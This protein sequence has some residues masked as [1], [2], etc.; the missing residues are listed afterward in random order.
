MKMLKYLPLGLVLAASLVGVSSASAA[1]W[2]PTTPVTGTQVGSSTLTAGTSQVT[3]PTG[4]TTLTASGDLARASGTT[5]PVAFGG[6]CTNS[7]GLSPTTVTT[8]G[9]WTFTAVDTTNVTAVATPNTVGGNVAEINIAGVCTITVPGPVTI[10]NND[11][12]NTTHRLVVNNTRTFDLR[13]DGI[14]CP[15]LPT[16]GTL[17]ATFQLPSTV[18]IT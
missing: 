8:T 16:T 6:A 1:N 9:E 7:F 5:N 2:D 12:S 3:C 10:P 4:H 11:W 13:T 18:I 14:L 15:T 17:N